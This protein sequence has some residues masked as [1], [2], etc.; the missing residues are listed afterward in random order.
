MMM[1]IVLLDLLFVNTWDLCYTNNIY[2]FSVLRL[3]NA[4]I[5]LTSEFLMKKFFIVKNQMAFT[6]NVPEMLKHHYAK[7]SFMGTVSKLFFCH[8]FTLNI[9]I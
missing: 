2:I 4:F 7:I 6:K 9:D 5:Y 1:I 8:Q 3:L